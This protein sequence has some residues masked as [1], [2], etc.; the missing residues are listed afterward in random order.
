M[1]AFKKK[2]FNRL[3]MT[4]LGLLLLAGLFDLTAPPLALAETSDTLEITGD[5]V[6]TPMTFTLAQLEAMEQYQHVY[7]TVNTWPT[8]KWYVGK[9]VKLRNLLALAGIKEDARLI[10]FVSNDGYEVTLTVKELLKDKRYYFPHL[11]DTNAGDGSVPGSPSGAEEVEPVLA[12]TGAEGSNDPANMNDMNSLLLIFGQRAVTEQTNNSFLK[13][14]IKIEALTT[15]PEKW[16]N[17]K[18]NIPD[19]TVIPGGTMIKLGNKHNNE[20]NIYYTTDGSDPTVNSPVFN[21]SASRWWPLRNDLDSINRPIEI[22]KNTVIKAVTIGPGKE[23]SDIV[24]Y[25]FT[26]DFTGRAADPAKIPGGPP[27]GV[28]LDRNTIDLKIGGTFQL[29][30][31]VAPYNAIDRDIIWSSSDTRVATVDNKGLVTVIGPGEAIITA[32]T[33]AGDYT[34]TCIVNGSNRKDGG[35]N[36]LLAAG[37]DSPGNGAL[38]ALEEPPAQKDDVRNPAEKD[39][40]ALDTAALSSKAPEV[41]GEPPATEDEWQYLA[42]KKDMAAN[43]AANS[44]SAGPGQPDGRSGQIFEMSTG[45]VTLQLQKEQNSLDIYAAVIFLIL[46]LSGAGRRYTEYTKEVAR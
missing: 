19:G 15:A 21:W 40:A 43:T 14:T 11:K 1:Q 37:S 10:R 39:V 46:F 34:A 24:T 5:G 3:L 41:S 42:E 8:K 27:T 44:V 29:A 18:A 25:I 36:T 30:A 2:W 28:S 38:E 33:K 7:S 6:K 13:Y 32:K 45:A 23:N 31:D 22:K 17:P 26:A 4:V 20:D 9:G 12:L 16:D 35:Q